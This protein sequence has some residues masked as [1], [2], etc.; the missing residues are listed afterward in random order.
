MTFLAICIHCDNYNINY[1]YDREER[2]H[3]EDGDVPMMLSDENRAAEQ[4]NPGFYHRPPVNAAV[5]DSP[6][7]EKAID[8]ILAKR[9]W[10]KTKQAAMKSPADGDE[11]VAVVVVQK[12]EAAVAVP[13][14]AT[15]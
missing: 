3:L 12:A 4:R 7:I 9:K 5:E 15:A 1:D 10:H 8:S 14:E 6:G 11:A 13:N 2:Q